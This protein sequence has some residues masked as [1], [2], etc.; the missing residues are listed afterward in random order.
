[1]VDGVPQVFLLYAH[2]TLIH[3]TQPER[4]VAVLLRIVE[5]FGTTLGLWVSKQKTVQFPLAALSH[6]A[7]DSLPSTEL[8]WIR[9]SSVT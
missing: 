3:F 7:R 1:M 9:V 2:D 5:E 6:R 4:L 8:G